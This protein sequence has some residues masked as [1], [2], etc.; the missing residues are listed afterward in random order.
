MHRV[1]LHAARILPLWPTPTKEEVAAARHA[2]VNR[3]RRS[4]GNYHAW[5]GRNGRWHCRT[6]L[7]ATFSI[8]GVHRRC[9]EECA[10]TSGT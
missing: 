8:D 10:G 1:I 5:V 7:A 4:V 9:M 6:C 3:A 2:Q